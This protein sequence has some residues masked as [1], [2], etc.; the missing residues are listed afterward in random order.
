MGQDCVLMLLDNSDFARD[1]DAFPSRLGAQLECATF[2]ARKLN[3]ENQANSFGLM[4]TAGQSCEILLTPS[5]EPESLFASFSKISIGG[6]S[7]I[8]RAI[9]VAMLVMKHRTNKN[10]TQKII[11]F[12]GSRVQADEG[13]LA[14]LAKDLRR[15]NIT[16]DIVNICVEENVP[17]LKGFLA[18]CGNED[19]GKLVHHPFS[20]KSVLESMQWGLYSM[21]GASAPMEE[22]VD[23]EYLM[24][25]QMSLEEA[26]KTQYAQ[27]NNVKRNTSG[28]MEIEEDFE[29]ISINPSDGVSKESPGSKTRDRS[30]LSDI[31]FIKEIIKDLKLDIDGQKIAEKMK[32]GHS[33]SKYVVQGSLAE[34]EVSRTIDQGQREGQRRDNQEKQE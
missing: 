33:A 18:A 27:N 13:R 12:V 3:N 14:N 25:V 23:Q 31:D 15:N 34:L 2:V 19:Y 21:K 20:S 26:E 9:Q 7:D 11:L 8:C 32:I 5:T 16:L 17:M 6:R 29:R 4:T 24:A 30:H 1:G 28:G 10:Q 22:D